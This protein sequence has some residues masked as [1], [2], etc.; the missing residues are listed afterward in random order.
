MNAEQIKALADALSVPAEYLIDAYAAQVPALWVDSAGLWFLLIMLV[1]AAIHV[2]K[3]A[4][5]A[6]EYDDVYSVLFFLVAACVI[7]FVIAA[8]SLSMAYRASLSPE[9][10]AISRILDALK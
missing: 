4:K 7:L 5:K 1:M 2:F 3:E 9:A 6:E 8:V 10:Y